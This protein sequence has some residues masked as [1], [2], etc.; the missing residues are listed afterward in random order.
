MG[1]G[2]EMTQQQQQQQ[3]QQ[4]MAQ[5]GMAQQA[6]QPQAPRNAQALQSAVAQTG[7]AT[8]AP[9]AAPAVLPGAVGDV[10]Y[11]YNNNAEPSSGG[12]SGPTTGYRLGPALVTQRRCTVARSPIT[13]RQ[14][15]GVL[16]TV[17]CHADL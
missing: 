8:Q 6:R 17:C 16:C 1:Q 9:P 11:V 10:P 14:S 12:K 7:A 13:K 2:A 15:G 4:V 3:Q 5:Q